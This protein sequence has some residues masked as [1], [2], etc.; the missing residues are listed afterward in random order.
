V[1]IDLH[2]L[3]A[4]MLHKIGEVDRADIVVV[5]EGG[6]LEGAVELLEK[7]AEP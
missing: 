7:L 4:L 5:D 3:H 1:K 6:A 2:V